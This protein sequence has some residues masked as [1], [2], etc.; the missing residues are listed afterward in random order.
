MFSVNRYSDLNFTQSLEGPK[1]AILSVAREKFKNKKIPH[2]YERSM[3]IQKTNPEENRE[4]E[5]SK[6]MKA[7]IILLNALPLNSVAIAKELTMRIR[8]YTYDE[9]VKR[10]EDIKR[11]YKS[12]INIECENFIRH[13]STKSTLSEILT[14]LC[15]ADK[16]VYSYVPGDFIFIITLK[17]AVRGQEVSEITTNDL[18]F[19]EL[20]LIR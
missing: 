8:F 2:A 7:R 1:S 13:P 15:C 12:N 9:F 5:N 14:S 3:R 17:Q 4:K 19:A 20:E 10:I 18:L 6:N 16:Q 11:L